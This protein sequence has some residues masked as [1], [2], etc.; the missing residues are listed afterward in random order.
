M[1]QK[2]KRRGKQ[3]VITNYIPHIIS[4]KPPKFVDWF[5]YYEK[6]LIN[7]HSI[8]NETLK[9]KLRRDSKIDFQSFVY[10]LYTVSSKFIPDF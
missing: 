4:N 7:L 1:N 10:F 2:Y 9:H 8:T 3:C 5:Q 6:E